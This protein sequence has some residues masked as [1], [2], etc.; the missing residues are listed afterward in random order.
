MRWR[1]LRPSSALQEAERHPGLRADARLHADL[2]RPDR[3]DPARRPWSCARRTLGLAGVLGDR[4]RRA[5]ARRAPRFASASRFARRRHQRRLRPDRRLGAGPLRVSRPPAARRLH[6][7]AVRAADRGRRH[8]ADRDLRAERLDR[9]ASRSRSASRSPTRRSASSSRSSSSACPSSCARS[10]RCSRTST[11]RSRRPRRR[12]APRA[13]RPYLRVVMPAL[14]PALLTGFALAFARAV[15]EYGSVIFIA[16]NIPYVSEIAPLLIVIRL[17]EFDYAGATAI[18]TIMLAHLL[19]PPP[20]HQPAAGVEP[21]EAR[22]CLRRRS[23]SR[24]TRRGSPR[25]V[26]SEA[27]GTRIVLIA[28]AVIFLLLLPAA[29]A[30]HR[31]RRGA[32]RRAS[33]PISPRSANPTRSSAITADAAR[34]GDRGAGQSRLRRRRRLGD[35]QVRV[36]GQELP[37]H[38]DRSALLG[39]AGDLG[40]DLRALF[41]AQGYFGPWLQAHGIQI[42]FAVPGIVLATIFVT[43][44]FVA[45]ELIPIMQEQGTR[46][47][48]AAL[49]LGAERLARPSSASRCP[50]SNGRCSTACSSAMPARWASS[51]P[52]R[53]SPAI[54]AGRPTPCRCRSRSSTTSTATARGL[55]GRLAARPARARHSRRQDGPRMALCRRNR[56]P[57]PP[58]RNEADGR[59]RANRYELRRRGGSRPAQ[60]PSW[61]APVDVPSRTWSRPSATLRRCTASRST[62]RSA[63]SWRCSAR[64]AR[65]RRRSCASSPGSTCRPPAAFSS[66]ARTR[67]A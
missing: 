37:D 1:R 41:G 20:R 55:R 2:S 38:A 30:G 48:E 10:S 34:R 31:L 44:P 50:T 60:L 8:R 23:Q 32:P 46:D 29:A 64:R 12:S 65:A 19:R 16:G 9:P 57:A 13:C 14:L 63:S 49:S 7:P 35:R 62:S 61:G 67:S 52:C 54:S 27:L 28:V 25:A 51:A 33:A 26:T 5:H 11:A 15:G 66:A 22:P 45:R 56:R 21:P 6:R 18:A 36:Q 40:P 59:G 4:H 17:T 47:E 3:A 43:F 24:T 58:L 42:I 39:L 53:W